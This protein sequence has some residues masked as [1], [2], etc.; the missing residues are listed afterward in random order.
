MY[1]YRYIWMGMWIHTE[2]RF[3]LEY[4]DYV[5]IYKYIVDGEVH[6]LGLDCIHVL[7]GVRWSSIP[8]S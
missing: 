3:D 5:Y 2:V 1:I 8:N 6:D 7:I 4:I